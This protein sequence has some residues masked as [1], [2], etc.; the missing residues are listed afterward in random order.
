MVK[1]VGLGNRV[2]KQ[3][4]SEPKLKANTVGIFPEEV[5]LDGILQKRWRSEGGGSGE[6]EQGSG[7]KPMLVW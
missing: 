3:I 5:G 1:P 6:V 2:R 7:L 4:T